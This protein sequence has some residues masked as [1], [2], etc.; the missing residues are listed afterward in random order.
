M[1]NRN[2]KQNKTF[3]CRVSLATQL[4]TRLI[5]LLKSPLNG[6]KWVTPIIRRVINSVISSY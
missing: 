2:P 5:T 6:L 3:L 4:I 1:G